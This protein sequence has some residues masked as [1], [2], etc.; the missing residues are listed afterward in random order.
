MAPVWHCP[1]VSKRRD[2]PDT[3]V[4]LRDEHVAEWLQVSRRTLREWRY[5]GTGPAFLV[6]GGRIRYRTTDVASY[7]AAQR[8]AP[9]S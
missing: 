8:V 1:T 7:L 6:V 3:D 9:E 4:L 5:L 2:A